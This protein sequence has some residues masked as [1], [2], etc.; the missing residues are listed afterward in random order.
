M[1]SEANQLG[2]NIQYP[3]KIS[4]LPD[5]DMPV[6]LYE[7]MGWLEEQIR[8]Y[9]EEQERDRRRGMEVYSSEVYDEGDLD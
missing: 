6:G 2:L 8:L 9:K 3:W 4:W 7:I 5:E 1:I